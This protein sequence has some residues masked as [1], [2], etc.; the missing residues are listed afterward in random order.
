MSRAYVFSPCSPDSFTSQY[1]MDS[2]RLTLETRQTLRADDDEY[3]DLDASR[4]RSTCTSRRNS[5]D[6]AEIPAKFLG[7]T[8]SGNPILRFDAASAPQIDSDRGEVL[9][10]AHNGDVIVMFRK[11]MTVV[12]GTP[13]GGN[14]PQRVA[15]TTPTPPPLRS[16]F[17]PPPMSPT[18]T[19]FG[20]PSR[21]GSPVRKGPSSCNNNKQPSDMVARLQAALAL[22]E[23]AVAID[24]IERQ[25]SLNRAAEKAAASRTDAADPNTPE[26]RLSPPPQSPQ[27]PQEPEHALLHPRARSIRIVHHPSPRKDSSPRRGGW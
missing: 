26:N 27:T 7:Y 20:T 15:S 19:L 3:D 1:R 18:P 2:I 21:S 13:G 9:G 6:A 22:D 16:P 5:L 4:M 25:K 24:D 17:S 23:D 11:G 8:E 10:R 14:T 12:T